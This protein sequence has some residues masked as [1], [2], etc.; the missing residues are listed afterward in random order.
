MSFLRRRAVL[1]LL[2]AVGL[3]TIS[4]C[5]K[6]GPDFQTPP[7]PD[8][9]PAQFQGRNPAPGQL[10]TTDRWWESF[11]DPELNRL[12]EEALKRN[13][14]LASA[15]ARV[16]ELLANFGQARAERFPQ[17]NLTPSAKKQ[18]QA[19][20]TITPVPQDLSMETESYNLSVA[21]SF[22]VDLWGRLART[23]EAARAD[24][25]Q[26][27]E[28]RRTVAQT[29]A[30]RVVTSYLTIE[31]LERRLGVAA[32]SLDATRQS[33]DRVEGRYR[34]GLVSVLDLYQA[35]R[36]LEEAKSKI[37]SLRQEL[38][39]EQQRLGIL[40]GRYPKTS[41]PRSQPADYFPDLPPVP[42]GLPSELLLRRP[43]VAAAQASLEAL[44]ARIGAA[45]AA[46]FPTLTLTGSWG[47]VSDGLESLIRPENELWNLTAGLVAPI[48]D[49]GL[50]KSRQ[51][52]AE[53]RYQQGLASWATTVLT[54]F[55]EV[56]GA[57]VVR[58]QQMARRELVQR[59]LTEAISTQRSAEERY[60]RGL[61][62]YISVLDA[63]STRYRLADELVLNELAI[64]TNRV[65]LY[66]A[67]GGGW[68]A[69][70]DSLAANNPGV[71]P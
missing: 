60:N 26:A 63:L 25:A 70:Q 47:Y 40:L 21:A 19:L 14:D 2:S 32:Q 23:E 4:G 10:V 34:R 62:E 7:A 67:L 41:P 31:A 45:K 16:L 46:R 42:A 37:P 24:L 52:A 43:D 12:V 54:A 20:G 3:L 61:V 55:S 9:V 39:Q 68:G 17:I 15:D 59:A 5:L 13:L 35:R 11:G 71:K 18:R 44:N 65:S 57:L 38:A 56:E 28:T 53:A 30:A 36:S 64:L 27:W 29:T 49:A 66:R 8:Q 51:D 1:L 33:L 58:Q 69:P 50:R 22:E 48:F 6:V